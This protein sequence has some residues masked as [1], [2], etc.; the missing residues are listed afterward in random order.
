V[1]GEETYDDLVKMAK[2]V[3]S[4]IVKVIRR[5][6]DGRVQEGVFIS[7]DEEA[8][9]RILQGVRGMEEKWQKK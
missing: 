7:L 8:T 1:T 4:R 5:D 3:G 2:T 6:E 9:D